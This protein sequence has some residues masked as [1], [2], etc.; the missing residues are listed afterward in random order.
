MKKKRYTKYKQKDWKTS[1][2]YHRD[3]SL[4]INKDTKVFLFID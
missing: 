4:I 2:N 3:V 1:S